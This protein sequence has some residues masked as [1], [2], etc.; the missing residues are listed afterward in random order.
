GA[1]YTV[2]VSNAASASATSGT[3]TVT[4]TLPSGLTL[5]SMAG[6]GWT[7]TAN[8]C[9]R[10]DALSGGSAYPAITVTVS[11][12]QNAVSPQVNVIAVSGGGSSS[13]STSDSTNIRQIAPVSVTPGSGGGGI[14][15][16][17]FKYADSFGATDIRTVWAY[18]TASFTSPLTNRCQ[19]YYDRTLNALYLLNDA[20]SAWLS[21]TPGSSGTLQNSQ[22][23]MNL[24]GASVS[25]T[26]YELTL[27]IPLTF[28]TSFTGDK[29]VWMY[30]SSATT[31]SGWLQL[32]T[33]TVAFAQ[34]TSISPTT[35]PTNS[36]DFTLTANG[37][38]FV[39]GSAIQWTSPLGAKTNL[40]TTFVDSTQLQAS[41]P[42]SLLT[43]PG[44]AQVAVLSGGV[45]TS[46]QPFGIT[47]GYQL[48]S[49]SPDAANVNR[50]NATLTVR[51]AG[52]VNGAQ[53]QW[54][55]PNGAVYSNLTTTFTNGLVLGATLPASLMTPAGAGSIRVV[56]ADSSVSNSVPLYVVTSDMSPV[57]ITPNS[58]SGSSQTFQ[59]RY[60]SATGAPAMGT[61]WLYIT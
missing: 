27:T 10:S 9:T 54:L 47:G 36:P 12:N 53:V 39:S 6:T 23:S 19:F 45:T 46:S 21:G 35:Q 18:I 40:T 4:E 25:S 57:S 43:M 30:A 58:G 60:A 41:V 29:Q 14:Q 24:S 42:A 7:C 13:A 16:F 61:A 17:Q 34:L 3:V 38:G 52:F 22:C 28:T 5:V 20:S 11:V 31:N 55:A 32:G 59:L 44:Q 56:N 51:G 15:T 33:W 26:A 37:T 48:I 1:T 8:S 49:V 50:G 2:V